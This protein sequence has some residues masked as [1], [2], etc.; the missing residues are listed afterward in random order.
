MSWRPESSLVRLGAV[1]L[2]V[3][4]SGVGSGA[5]AQ[6]LEPRT[7][8]N[9]P[10]GMNFLIVGYGYGSGSVVADASIPLENA[11]LQT[12][13]PLLAYARALDVWGKSGKIDVVLPSARISGSAE[14]AGQP[15]ERDVSGFGDP[16]IRFSVNF[17]GAPAM[18]LEEFKHYRQD[19]IIGASLQVAA[20][21]GQYDG[22]RLVNIGTNRWAIKPE[23]GVSKTLGQ[24]TLELSAAAT[25]FTD[26]DN[27]LGG[28]TRTQD[29]LYALQAHVI[30]GFRSGIWVAA[31]GTYYAGGRTSLDGVANPDRQENSRF[32]LTVALPLSRHNSLKLFASSGAIARASG[33][34]DI[35][36][37]AW[38][39]RWGGGL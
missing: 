18:S 37:M 25:V 36:G 1:L 28:Q 29:P 15:Q 26:N 6:S 7:Y 38:Q 16:R 4:L 21:L 3:C 8:S 33:D 13:G 10:V 27:F 30:Y 39:H 19:L 17:H 2:A 12:H 23:L 20:P 24:W 9:T 32:G 14:F 31:D 5:S 35:V 11:S 34:F 22:D